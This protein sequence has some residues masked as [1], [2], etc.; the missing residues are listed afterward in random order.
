MWRDLA[1]NQIP[2]AKRTKVDPPTP[3]SQLNTTH[4]EIKPPPSHPHVALDLRHHP[5]PPVPRSPSSAAAARNIRST[6]VVVDVA[7]SRAS[8]AAALHKHSTE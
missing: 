6:T 2:P 4:R 7:S 3:P 8:A 1:N 5:P